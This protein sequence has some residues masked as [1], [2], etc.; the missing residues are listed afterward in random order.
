MM[1]MMATGAPIPDINERVR[2]K[3]PM[4]TPV[5]HIADTT[6]MTSHRSMTGSVS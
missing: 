4:G 5:F 2:K 3:Q 1:P 6:E